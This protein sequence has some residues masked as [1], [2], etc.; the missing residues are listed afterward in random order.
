MS[1]TSAT[2]RPSATHRASRRRALPELSFQ[3]ETY[4]TERLLHLP[5]DGNHGAAV[6]ELHKGKEVGLTPTP[7]RTKVDIALEKA[8]DEV[9]ARVLGTG[10]EDSADC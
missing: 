3:A 7:G 1:P 6:G 2:R 8:F 4:W 9:G 10:V 5:L